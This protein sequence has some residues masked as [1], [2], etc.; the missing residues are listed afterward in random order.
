M[1]ILSTNDD[2]IMAPGLLAMRRSL[3]A[4]GEV[5][6]AAPM[7][8][9]SACGHAISLN[10]PVVCHRMDLGDG[11]KGY[12]IEGSP[13]DCVKLA[14]LELLPERPD[15]VVSG[16]NLGE[17][18]G[19]NVLYS[20]TVAAAI[21]AAF[22]GVPSV[23]VSLESADEV[24]FERAAEVARGLVEQIAAQ[25]P[26]AGTMV[27]INLPNLVA[28][29]PAGL[30][31]VP[32]SI[33]SWNDRWDRRQDPQGRTYYWMYGDRPPEE[34]DRSDVAALAGR[35]VTVTPLRF[36]LTDHARLDEVEGW[37]LHL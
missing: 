36:D 10:E 6:V 28:G 23:A 7:T 18:A 27:N 33:R 34:G 21:E 19:I 16:I 30:R 2:G 25:R 14:L 13:A 8:A 1:R 26:P 32:Q 22:Y 29:P 35:Y 17:N 31:V 24:D 15:L 3:A 12:G 5:T 37:G 4:V 9:Q 11:V 20:G